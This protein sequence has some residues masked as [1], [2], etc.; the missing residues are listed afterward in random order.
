[1]TTGINNTATETKC[2]HCASTK[3]MNGQTC[4]DCRQDI[5]RL[6]EQNRHMEYS[7]SNPHWICPVA[8]P[9]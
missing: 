8:N 3:N 2:A 4:T 6:C 9:L 5:C 7:Y 1:M